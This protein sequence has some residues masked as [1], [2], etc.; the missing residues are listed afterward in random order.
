MTREQ[1]LEEIIDVFD[2]EMPVTEDT[3]LD[4]IDEWDSLAVVSLVALYHQTFGIRP[5]TM[6]L[7]KCKTVKDLLD[8]AEGKLSD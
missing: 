2:T 6:E 5:N 4:S 7:R 3:N 1:L 8:L